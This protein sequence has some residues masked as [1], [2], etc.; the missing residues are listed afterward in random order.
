MKFEHTSRSKTGSQPVCKTEPKSV[1]SEPK[2][3]E[4]D[5]DD[6][7]RDSDWE[8]DNFDNG[9]DSSP[10]VTPKSTPRHEPEPS[11]EPAAEPDDQKKV[12]KESPTKVEEPKKIQKESS[13]LIDDLCVL[14]DE[15][16]DY[17]SMKDNIYS[18][19]VPNCSEKCNALNRT[20][21]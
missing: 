2:L 15:L 12:Q 6:K 8:P 5:E 3:S 10:E 9:R 20:I 21:T 1:K 11:P 7:D 13:T 18:C 4:T 19:K 14:K 16:I 17:W